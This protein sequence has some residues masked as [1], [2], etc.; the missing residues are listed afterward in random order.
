MNIKYV[1]RTLELPSDLPAWQAA[2]LAEIDTKTPEGIKRPSQL[3]RFQSSGSP[4]PLWRAGTAR[5]LL[6]PCFH[7]PSAG[8][9]IRAELPVLAPGRT[10][11]SGA[12]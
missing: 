11:P 4:T 6:Q 9:S 1:L 5:P 7:E 2:L 3:K 8:A 10:T 12:R